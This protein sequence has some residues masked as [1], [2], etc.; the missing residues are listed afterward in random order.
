MKDRSGKRQKHKKFNLMNI[1]KKF[2]S[3]FF[4]SYRT[5]ICDAGVEGIDRSSIA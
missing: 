4:T 3:G 2:D 5:K 1:K